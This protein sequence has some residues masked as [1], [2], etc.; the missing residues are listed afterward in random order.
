MKKETISGVH[1][2]NEKDIIYSFFSSESVKGDNKEDK[3]QA[4]EQQKKDYKNKY[5]PEEFRDSSVISKELDF[6]HKLWTVQYQGLREN[7]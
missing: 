3:N 4:N 2:N 6:T 1:K 5:S 7:R